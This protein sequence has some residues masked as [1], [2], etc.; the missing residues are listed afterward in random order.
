ML[1]SKQLLPQNALSTY[2]GGRV[3]MA[4]HTEDFDNCLL[5]ALTTNA[6]MNHQHDSQQRRNTA[7]LR[8]IYL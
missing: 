1:A 6:M 2:D 3:Q 8:A 4:T 5:A 7:V